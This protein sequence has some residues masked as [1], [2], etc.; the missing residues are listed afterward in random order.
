MDNL[1]VAPN[2]NIH[3]ISGEPMKPA[4][5]KRT[6]LG[7]LVILIV[8][9]VIIGIWYWIAASQTSQSKPV[10]VV[11]KPDI[12]AQ[13]AALLEIAP[14]HATPTEISKVAALLAKSKSTATDSERAKVAEELTR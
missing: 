11:S 9:G 3:P 8:I 13:V 2:P 5:H 7:L 10:P 12:R 4:E 1:P 6:M 14:N